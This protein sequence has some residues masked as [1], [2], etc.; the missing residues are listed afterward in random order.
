MMINPIIFTRT[1]SQGLVVRVPANTRR[2]QFTVWLSFIGVL[3]ACTYA[4]GQGD[5]CKWCSRR[6]LTATVE[7]G[8]SPFRLH[9][10]YLCDSVLCMHAMKL[11]AAH[12]ALWA[13]SQVGETT[14]IHTGG[15]L[16]ATPHVWPL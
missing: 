3:C 15:L 7:G 5:W 4:H 6:R 1:R 11:H 9:T 8:H 12:P 14:Q 10:N 16:Q 13:G 2:D